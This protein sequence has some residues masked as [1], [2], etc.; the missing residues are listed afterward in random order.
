MP[1]MPLSRESRQYRRLQR[2]LGAYR[3]VMGQPRQDDLIKLMGEDVDWPRIDLRP[4]Q[5]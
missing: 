3:S 5:P 2:T 1:A 4:P